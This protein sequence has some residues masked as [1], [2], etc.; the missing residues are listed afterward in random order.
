MKKTS[1]T[2]TVGL[3]AQAAGINVEAI[4]FYQRK[5]LMP[6]PERAYGRIRRYTDADLDRVRF[7]KAS[8]RLG[9]SLAEVGELLKLDD[10]MHCEEA[11]EIAE[12]KLLDVREKL[13]DLQRI[14][15][16]LDQLVAQCGS[17]HNAVKC[18]LIS[19]LH[20]SSEYLTKSL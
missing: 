1:K 15:R 2:L 9:F 16:A 12:H 18:P 13:A 8:Q 14:E 11:R 5:G 20:E 6:L 7:I 3:L 10:G 19:A 4:R 17:A